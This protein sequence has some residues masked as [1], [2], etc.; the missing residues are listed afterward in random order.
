MKKLLAEIHRR[1]LWQVL[2][3]YLAGSWIALQVVETL[4]ES[5]SL[6][7]WVP[8]LALVLLVI[9]FPIVMATAF[10]QHGGPNAGA[11]RESEL[12]AAAGGGAESAESSAA[13]APESP[14][15]SAP[16]E[17]G[18][19]AGPGEAQESTAQHRF[20]TWRNAIAGGVLAFA[21]LGFLAAGWLV[22][23]QL[24]IG[25]AATLVAKGVLE[26]RA[27]VLVADFENTAG[28]ADLGRTATL[29]LRTDLGQSRVITVVA[30]TQVAEVLQRM[31]RPADARLDLDLARE[32]AIREG[33]AAVIT[34]EITSAGS[35]FV[36]AGR[37]VDAAS[38]EVLLSD[39]VRADDEGAILDAIDELSE[40]LRERIGESLS[41][42]RSE[43]ALADVTTTDLEALRKY[44][45]AVRAIETEGNQER[46]IALLEEAVDLDPDFA[47]AWRKLG[48]ELNNR[49]EDRART[50]EAL[51]RAFE[52]KD[53]L[54]RREEYLTAATY[55]TMVT[56]ESDK[57]VTAYENLLDLEPDNDA[58]L[59]NL[60]NAYSALRD[61]PRAEDY[62]VRAS[63]IDSSN[64]IP[65]TNAVGVQVSLGKNDAALAMI[66]RAGRLF[67]D[68]P[69]VRQ[70]RAHL[71]AVEGEPDAAADSLEELREDWIGSLFWRGALAH[72]LATFAATRGHMAAAEEL[73]RDELQTYELRDLPGEYL[74]AVTGVAW[75]DL[76]VRDDR[77][78][79]LARVGEAL[80]GHPLAEI[81][82][83]DRPYLELAQ[84]YAA[85]G[86]PERARELIAEY[87]VEVPANARRGLEP[88]ELRARGLAD[89]AEGRVAEGLEQIRR[90]DFGQ[91]QMCAE[92]LAAAATRQIDD[93]D[94]EIEA[95]E[96][97]VE[98]PDLFRV[99]FDASLLG[100]ALERLGRL[101]DE[102]GEAEKAAEY[103]ARLVELWADA[104]EELQ[105][106]VRAAQTRLEEIVRTRG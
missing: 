12:L 14:P 87:E 5:A 1:S 27:P 88:F 76:F 28:A 31:D 96:A 25:P 53:R 40:S 44:T 35:A 37:M 55:Y 6:P 75:L 30:P 91:C 78:R 99:Y 17:S 86:R 10:V 26:D 22:T 56:N 72:D 102:R 92:A 93:P 2:G 60:G 66:D 51:T 41:T 52:L 47:M 79:A 21:L 82:P 105:P 8:A 32:V 50:V 39:R 98:S 62:F 42:L 100:P 68:D 106:R 9:G 48:T 11:V 61:L 33:Y 49:R 90:S 46:G 58:A 77:D 38:G 23:R 70:Y 4:T 59:N 36:V 43:P 95:L 24:G 85:S 83:L 84:L 29:A 89:V 65:F 94:L 15:V 80:A 63:V 73:K 18:A 81:A 74:E 103:Y 13:T 97:W 34:G 45:E 57:A 101:Y 7:D 69:Y 67:P 16:P 54:T 64:S 104:D 20:F 3:L 71:L 19:V